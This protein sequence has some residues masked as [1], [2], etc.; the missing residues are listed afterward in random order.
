MKMRMD[1]PVMANMTL[2]VS[3]GP[4]ISQGFQGTW[5][6]TWKVVFF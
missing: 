2:Q 5:F 3:L 6:H 4:S 1:G